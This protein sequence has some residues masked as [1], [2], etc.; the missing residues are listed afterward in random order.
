MTA[1]SLLSA[2]NSSPA[3]ST[4]RSH[5]AFARLKSPAKP[6]SCE[7]TPGITVSQSHVTLLMSASFPNASGH[8]CFGSKPRRKHCNV[9]ARGA[10]EKQVEQDTD[11]PQGWSR[12]PSLSDAWRCVQWLALQHQL[13]PLKLPAAG[14]SY[15]MCHQL[16]SQAVFYSGLAL[17]KTKT[18]H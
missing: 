4:R 2:G 17:E 11:L 5:A 3:I 10:Q 18:S 13:L 6:N 16:W 1:R 9:V 14:S 8:A 15:V 12:C 7:T